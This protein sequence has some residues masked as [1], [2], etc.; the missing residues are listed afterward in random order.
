MD[1]KKIDSDYDYGVITD[2]QTLIRQ[3]SG[4]V[5]C[6]VKF[7]VEGEEEIGSTHLSEYLNLYKHKFRCDVVIWES[8]F[9]DTIGRPII[10]LGQKGILSVEIIS[11]G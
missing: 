9:I 5:P 6:N 2:L 8:G 7:I 11:K 1:V 4:D 10:S 3:P